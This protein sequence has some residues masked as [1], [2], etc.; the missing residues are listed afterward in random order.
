VTRSKLAL[1]A[2]V[3]IAGIVALAWVLAARSGPQE[4]PQVGLMT[5]LPIYWSEDSAFEATLSQKLPQ[6]WAR[7]H[8]ERRYRLV[9]LDTLAAADTAE[10]SAIFSE[11]KL[12]VLAQPRPLAPA[13]FAALDTWVRGGGRALIFADPMLTEHSE[14]GIGDPRRPQNSALMSPIFARWGLRQTF[15]E[16]QTEEVSQVS[17]EGNSIPVHLFGRFDLIESGEAEC[18]VIAEG[19]IADCAIGSGR[20][21]VVGDAALIDGHRGGADQKTALKLLLD[22]AFFTQ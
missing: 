9:P 8:L 15:D 19:L 5:S 21:F 22:R 1:G 20:A 18:R 6:H 16:I 10:P 17:L 12:L 2:V 4:K 11:L 7:I 3:V 14:M 13:D